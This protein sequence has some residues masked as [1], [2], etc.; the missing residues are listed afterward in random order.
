MKTDHQFLTRLEE[1][2]R[3]N[4]PLDPGILRKAREMNRG[5]E[6]TQTGTGAEN[7]IYASSCGAMGVTISLSI[8]NVSDRDIRV[9]ELQVE[10]PWFDG[11]FHWLQPLSSNAYVLKPLGPYP[12]DRSVVLNDK[13]NRNFTVL[14]GHWQ[15]GLLLGESSTMVPFEY[16]DRSKLPVELK[17]LAGGGRRYST[18]VELQ[19]Q[20]SD[21]RRSKSLKRV[22]NRL[23][24]FHPDA[25]DVQSEGN[26]RPSTHAR[27]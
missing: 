16:A 10:M 2:S 12:F 27:K 1:L 26:V 18:W 25:R 6:I 20:R 22:G 14:A 15:E 24:L 23:P 5:L 13:L 3:W 9:V 11:D 7:A 19:V 17:I 4:V 8:D 21:Q